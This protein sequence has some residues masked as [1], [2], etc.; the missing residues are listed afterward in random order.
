VGIEYNPKSGN[1]HPLANARLVRE[2]RRRPAVI[3]GTSSDRIG[4]PEGQSVN[5][6]ASKDIKRWTG[7]PVAPYVGLAYGTYEEELRVVGGVNVALPADFSALLIFDGVHL[8]PT[9][10]W[11]RDRH[12][13]GLI[14]VRS[15]DV[16]FSYSVRF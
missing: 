4:T 10:H 14:L 13:L 15:R 7:L 9:F 16:G 5:V 2:G 12:S 11:S 6:T 1:V 3:V 8:H